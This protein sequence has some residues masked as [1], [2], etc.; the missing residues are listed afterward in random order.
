M[1]N[2]I[3]TLWSNF[4]TMKMILMNNVEWVSGEGGLHMKFSTQIAIVFPS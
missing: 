1:R 3:L 2:N 4:L